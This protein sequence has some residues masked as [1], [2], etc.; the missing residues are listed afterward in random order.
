M[1]AAMDTIALDRELAT[2]KVSSDALK[3]L[4]DAECYGTATP[5]QWLEKRL[6]ILENFAVSG[7]AI[8][9]SAKS[10]P[11]KISNL[12]DFHEWC[13]SSFPDAYACFYAK[14]R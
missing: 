6:K 12:E 4:W 7:K 8:E 11:I 13:Q 9:V 1:L 14:R 2:G 10:G 3:Q 5:M